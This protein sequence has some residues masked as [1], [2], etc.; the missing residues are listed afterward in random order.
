MTMGPI[1]LCVDDFGEL[2]YRCR[3]TDAPTW[4]SRSYIVG[5]LIPGVGAKYMAALG[6]EHIQRQ[7]AADFHEAEG[8]CNMCRHLRRLPKP[9]T[10]DGILHGLCDR[11]GEPERRRAMQSMLPMDHTMR[12]HPHDPLHMPCWQARDS[13]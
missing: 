9:K 6:T 12:F 8:N 1:P 7:Q 11:P 4:A 13:S 3:H 5:S 10:A 2:V